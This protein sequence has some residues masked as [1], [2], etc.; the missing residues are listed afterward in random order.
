MPRAMIC[1]HGIHGIRN[2]KECNRIHDREYLRI[3]R[4]NHLEKLKEYKR[5]VKE[6]F[7]KMLGGKCQNPKCSTPN[8]YDRCL[9]ALEFHHLNPEDKESSQ[10][11]MRKDFEQKIIEGKIQLL[12]SNCHREKHHGVD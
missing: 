7:I 11:R 12:C 5:R 3:W 6:K 9:S 2:C 1:I 10:E 4:K 8:G